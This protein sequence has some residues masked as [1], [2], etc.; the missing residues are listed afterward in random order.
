ME[1]QIV[2]IDNDASMR[3]LL[4]VCL[5]RQGWAV[6][7]YDYAN[8]NLVSLEEDP[9]D[10][11]ILDFNARDEAI[12]W[13]FLQLLKMEDKMSH[14]PILITTTAF[15]LSAEVW[16]Y[17]FTRYIHV[18]HKPF[19]VKNLAALVLKTLTQAKRAGEIFSS[20]QPLPILLV[21][22][23]EDLQDTVTA[24]LR[25]EGYHVVAASN[26]LTALNT[27]SRA[28]YA[29]ILLDIAMPIM[30]GFEFLSAYDRQLRPHSPV[31]IL[32][33]EPDIRSCD[34][35]KFVVD[36]VRKPFEMRQL[37]TRVERFAQTG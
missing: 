10:L 27:V 14:I 29:L 36:F 32:S 12:G 6:S 21:D 11:I 23:T 3:T 30:N 5:N 28:D 18:I 1:V 15:Q 7:S 9:P 35:P 20:E 25:L 33:G 16:D 34:L 17:L 31:I 22:D 19:D 26:G 24:I 8:I 2:V 37:M 4:T 13:D